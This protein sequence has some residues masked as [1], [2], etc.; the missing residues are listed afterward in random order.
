MLVFR[1]VDAQACSRTAAAA[2][3]EVPVQALHGMGVR[4]VPCYEAHLYGEIS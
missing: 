1:C 2:K 4:M 3:Q